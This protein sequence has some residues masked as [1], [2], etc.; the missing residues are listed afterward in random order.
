MYQK[1]TE[2][3]LG[4][5]YKDQCLKKKEIHCKGGRRGLNPV[6]TPG[7]IDFSFLKIFHCFSSFLLGVKGWGLLKIVK[8]LLFFLEI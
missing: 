8:D 2:F 4:T 7:D 3:I 5:V 1:T 6:H